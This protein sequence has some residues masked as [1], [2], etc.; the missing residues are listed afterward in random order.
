MSELSTRT[1][2]NLGADLS[3]VLPAHNEAS[4]LARLLPDLATRY[5][6]AEI[7]VVDDAS[8]DNTASVCDASG[9]RRLT[10]PQT[11]GNGAAIKAGARRARGN[12]LVFM[13]ADGQHAPAE[14]QNLLALLVE[15]YDLAVGARGRSAQ[16]SAARWAANTFY[17]RFASWFV[18]HPVADLTSG[19]RACHA[20]VFREFLSL[21]PNGFSYPTTSTMAF[22]RAGYS[23]G[24]VPIEAVRRHGNQPSHIRPF[25]DGARFFLIIFRIGTLYSPLKLFL[26]V[27]M[28]FFLSGLG[29]YC[30]KAVAN[31][32]LMFTNGTG[33]LFITAILVFL[34]GLVSEQI[35][36]LVYASRDAPPDPS[37][38]DDEPDR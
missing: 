15:G 2:D 11:K 19:F 31:G 14:I 32:H 22:F 9:V 13:D 4:E 10:H 6:A 8:T 7:L 28:L 1:I 27:S 36:Q 16:A 5:P 23:V 24:Y 20:R 25:R 26:P 29:Y 18:G 21:L 37:Q 3:I 30:F 34:I 17:N 33:L 12:V 35:T 38:K